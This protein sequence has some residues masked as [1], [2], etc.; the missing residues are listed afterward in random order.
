MT[1]Y[2]VYSLQYTNWP[3]ESQVGLGVDLVPALERQ[4]QKDLSEFK[5]GPIN[6]AN[7]GPIRAT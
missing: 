5:A 3:K 1:K 7:L 2:I 6:M 4:K